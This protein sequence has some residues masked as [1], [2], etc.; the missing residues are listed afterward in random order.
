MPSVDYRTY[1]LQRSGSQV[2]VLDRLTGELLFK[3]SGWREA[4]DYA[5]KTSN[6]PSDSDVA[7]PS[8][9]KRR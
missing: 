1:R 7:V 8:D 6:D 9:Q 3:G 5:D 4:F 2:E